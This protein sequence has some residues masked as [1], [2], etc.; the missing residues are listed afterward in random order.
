MNTLSLRSKLALL[1]TC[2]TMLLTTTT[3]LAQSN[4]TITGTVLDS[5]GTPITSAAIRIVP[6]GGG[7]SR[8]IT[9]DTLG[10]FSLS[11]LTPGLYTLEFTAKGFALDSRHIAVT[12]GQSADISV[13]LKIDSVSTEVNVEADATHSIAAALAPMDASLDAR[14]ARTSITQH[15]IQNFTSPVSDFGEAVEMAPGTFTTNGNGVGL[16]QS[17]TYFRGFPDG[18]YDIDFD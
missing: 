3:V 11:A 13:T 6:E 16:G 15:F 4:G 2:A 14:S 10:R 8:T 9:T 12:R 17:S 7:V 18:N 1:A 5:K